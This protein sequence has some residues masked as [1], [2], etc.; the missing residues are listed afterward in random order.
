MPPDSEIRTTGS[1]P[2]GRGTLPAEGEQA[3]L[4]RFIPARAGNTPERIISLLYCPG[5][6]PRGRGTLSGE[7]GLR[8]V[9]RFIPARAGN[10]P[11]ASAAGRRG[12][13]H[14][15]AG[16]EH[17]SHAITSTPVDGSSPRGRGTRSPRASLAGLV[18][19]IPARAGNTA[20]A[21]LRVSRWSVHPR[22]G[23]E[24]TEAMG[25]EATDD[26]SSPR[27]RGTPSDCEEGLVGTRF[28]PARAG[29]TRARPR[30]GSRDSVH[31]RAGGE[32]G[33]HFAPGVVERGSSPR[34]RG[35]LRDPVRGRVVRRFIPARAGNT[36]SHSRDPMRSPV[37]PRAGGEHAN[38]LATG[39]HS[40]GSSR[41]GGEHEDTKGLEEDA[42]GS[43][44]RGRGTHRHHRA[45]GRRRRFIP[46][47]AGNTTGSWRRSR[48]RTV[49]P[50]AGGEHRSPSAPNAPVTGS[51]PRGR[52]THRVG[53]A[54][55]AVHRFI[56]AR[57]GNTTRRRYRG[58][59]NPVHPR[60]GGEHCLPPTSR[61]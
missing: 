5:S 59:A 25:V 38:A 7:L 55:V 61:T 52:G 41:A 54:V 33:K 32:H 28:I 34:G 58:L 4:V 14:P 57:A 37:H 18:R 6:S 51:S 8:D 11:S 15:R 46:A 9:V 48:A 53:L 23:G 21:A 1:S 24:H 39:S 50:R 42:I 17:S 22:A 40:G 16:G 35:T 3:C 20:R 12:P 45:R 19:F 60:A 30:A 26:G 27:G 43:S 29:N 44:P 47:R 56:P 10:T 31:P 2:R 36:S 49:H 13:V